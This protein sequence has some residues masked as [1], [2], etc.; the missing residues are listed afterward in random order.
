MKDKVTI[1]AAQI[2]PAIMKNGENLEKMLAFTAEAS[3][4]GADL[5]VF[6]ECALTGYV[7]ESREE[8]LPHMEP[9][10]GPGTEKLAKLCKE[11]GVYVV[12]GMLETERDKCFNT[13]VLVGP[14]GLAGK[15]RKNHLP[16][17]GIDRFLDRGDLLFPVFSTSI[18]NIGMLI[19]Y[20]CNFPESARVLMLKGADNVALPT[21]WPEGREKAP[22]YVVVTRAIENRVHLAAVNRTGKERG[23][24][25]IGT[26]KIINALGDTLADASSD[27]EQII[28]GEVK[29][30]ESRNKHVVIKPGEFEIDMLLDR[31]PDIYTEITRID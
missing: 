27:R 11:L 23:T 13:A 25:F 21:N 28:Y 17:L 2:D 14:Q 20:D 19:C 3:G 30:S 5:V 24:T 26:S 4:N 18:G 10:P 8:A 15:Y 6:P 9:V 12:M 29:L 1:A 7:F 22:G 16:F 31:R